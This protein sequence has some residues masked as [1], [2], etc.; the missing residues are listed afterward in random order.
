M[1]SLSHPEDEFGSELRWMT[2]GGT[3]GFTATVNE[4]S[5]MS[6]TTKQKVQTGLWAVPF[7]T[8]CG[9]YIGYLASYASPI[10]VPATL[11]AVPIGLL[12]AGTVYMMDYF[13]G[14]KKDEK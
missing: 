3:I 10:L 6:A 14:N 9:V 7:G 8:G 2:F 13:K 11:L 12:G 1:S 4:V 5:Q